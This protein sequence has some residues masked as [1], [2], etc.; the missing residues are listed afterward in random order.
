[1]VKEDYRVLIR[2]PDLQTQYYNGF[3]AI[4]DTAIVMNKARC[5]A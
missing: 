1:M 5:I 4:L 2:K 3:C